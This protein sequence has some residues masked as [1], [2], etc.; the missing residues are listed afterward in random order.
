MDKGTLVEFSHRQEPLLGIIQGMDG[1]KNL[2]VT[3]LSGQ[4]YSIHPRQ[5]LFATRDPQ[6][7]TLSDLQTLAEQTQPLLDPEQVALLWELVQEERRLFTLEELAE[8]LFSQQ[9]S[10]YLYATHRLLSQDQVYFKSKVEREIFGYEPRPP[11]QVA[12]LRHRLQVTAQREQEQ[13][14]FEA[15]LRQ[16]WQGSWVEWSVGERRKLEPLERFVLQGDN[17]PDRS[18]AI[19]LLNLL[20]QPP[21]ESAALE[22]LIRLGIWSPHENLYVRRSGLTAAFPGEVLAVVETYLAQPPPDL[23]PRRDLSHLHTYTIDDA[24]TAEI[25]DALSVEP[26]PDGRTRLWIHIAD[27]SRWVRVGDPLDR[28]A[29]KRGTTVY[30]PEQSIPMFPPALATGPMSL[31]QGQRRHA[32][33]F[34]VILHADGSIAEFEI[35]PSYIQVT[36]RLTYED[37]DE[38]LELHAE[39]ALNT[40]AAQAQLRYQWRLSQGAIP[41]EFPECHVKVENNQP[42]LSVI[43]ETPARKL[44]AEMMILAGEITARYAAQHGI[45]VPYRLQSRPELPADL[46][47]LP[48]GPLRAWAVVRCMNKAEISLQ[49]GPHAGLGLPAYC[50]ATSPIRRYSDLVVHFQLKAHLS[51]IPVP[52]RAEEVQQIVQGLEVSVSEANQVERKT[53]RYWITEYFRLHPQRVWRAQVLGLLRDWENLAMVMIDDIGFRVGVKFH[54]QVSPGEWVNLTLRLADPRQEI[55]ELEEAGRLSN[56]PGEQ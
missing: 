29:R 25:D 1:K 51:G 53:E 40:L 17:A 13:A 37:A 31:V 6:I 22:V 12:E 52:F 16:A 15:H 46:E 49:P 10:L 47:Q 39:T 38:M 55:L 2:L 41:I 4:S 54:R 50:Q 14:E 26:L 48:P 3:A 56:S 19:K 5:I 34:A 32:L 35:V 23:C 27:P 11:A 44:V 43:E 33:S 8:L 7:Q 24:S 28:E 36:Y 18:Q 45:P 42:Q 9:G 30:L 20:Q 21:T